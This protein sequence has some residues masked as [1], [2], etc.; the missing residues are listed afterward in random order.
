M[1]KACLID[2]EERS[3]STLRQLIEKYCTEIT[4][5]SANQDIESAYQSILEHNP[6][7]IFLDIAMPRGSGFDLLK[8]FVSIHFEVVFVTAYDEYAIQAIKASALDYLLKPISIEELVDTVKR[9][10]KRLQEKSTALH[11]DLLLENLNNKSTLAGR[12]AIPSHK[13]FELVSFD[14]VVKIVADGSYT[15]VFLVNG[16]KILTTLHLNDFEEMLPKTLFFRSHHSFIINLSQIR[17]YIK[18]DGGQ[19]MMSD[20]SYVDIAKRKKKGVFRAA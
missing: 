2:D 16:I 7:V 1:I 20:Q 5:V 17:K 3:L 8:R 18:G 14:Q 13:G 10:K 9:I 15:Q 12:V 6:D 19:V 11:I 4:I